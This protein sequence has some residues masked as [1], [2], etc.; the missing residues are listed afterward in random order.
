VVGDV[1]QIA[2]LGVPF[3]AGVQPPEIIDVNGE[4]LR[5]VGH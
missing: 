4:V 1:E 2:G 5:Q 3:Q